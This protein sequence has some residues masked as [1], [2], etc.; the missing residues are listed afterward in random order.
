ME[1]DIRKKTFIIDTF[2]KLTKGLYLTLE[3]RH[4]M[5]TYH[6]SQYLCNWFSIIPY[7]TF[8]YF[9]SQPC[10]KVGY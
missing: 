3:M 5:R 9:L 6:Y 1:V 2:P 10:P 4:I 7:L 8:H